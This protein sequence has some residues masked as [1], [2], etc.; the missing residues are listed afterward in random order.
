MAAVINLVKTIVDFGAFVE[1]MPG[2][3]GLVHISEIAHRRIS[4]VDEVLKVGDVVKVELVGFE[5]GGKVR[6]S[7]KSLIPQVDPLQAPQAAP[8]HE[9]E[10]HQQN[11]DQGHD[12]DQQE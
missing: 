8:A 4:R 9:Q 3:D 12:Q 1:F 2:R 6:L 7:M 5:R 11:E 10:Q